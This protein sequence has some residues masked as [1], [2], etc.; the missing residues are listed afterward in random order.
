MKRER[1]KS[2]IK[3]DEK[4]EIWTEW[5]KMRFCDMANEYDFS[6][7]TNHS[8][9]LVFLI[10]IFKRIKLLSS[11]KINQNPEMVWENW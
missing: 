3:I 2:Q 6:V 11:M 9:T 7:S 1:R 10:F 8:I 4:I 5:K